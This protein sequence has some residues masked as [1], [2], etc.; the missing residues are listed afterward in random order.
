MRGLG[1]AVIGL[2]VLAGSAEGADLAGALPTKAP[3]PVALTKVT[4]AGK[5]SASSTLAAGEGPRFV[6]V[7]E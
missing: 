6:T 3:P 1:V 5:V 7:T 4:P 2:V